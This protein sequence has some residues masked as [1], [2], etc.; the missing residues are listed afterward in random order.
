MKKKRVKSEGELALEA[1][2]EAEHEPEKTIGEMTFWE[3]LSRIAWVIAGL[4][5]GALLMKWLWP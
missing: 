4:L 5:G 2:W 1:M 3:L